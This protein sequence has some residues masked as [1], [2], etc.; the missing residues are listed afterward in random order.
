MK[1][2]QQITYK[3]GEYSS[4]SYAVSYV[5]MVNCATKNKIKEAPMSSFIK[6]MLWDDIYNKLEK[7]PMVIREHMKCGIE[8]TTEFYIDEAGRI[9]RDIIFPPSWYGKNGYVKKESRQYKRITVVW[10]REVKEALDNYA[11][12]M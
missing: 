7:G 1:K 9:V 2:N 6:K 10:L 5:N 4:F 8:V 12:P 3:G 11:V